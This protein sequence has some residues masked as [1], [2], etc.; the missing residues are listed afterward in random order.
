[1]GLEELSKGGIKVQDVSG[2]HGELCRDP[3]FR[4]WIDILAAC[5]SESDTATVDSCNVD[6]NESC[7]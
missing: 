5:L 1:M 4:Y 2:Y 6:A 7:F 3:Y